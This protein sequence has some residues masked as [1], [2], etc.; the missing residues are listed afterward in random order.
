MRLVGGVALI[1]RVGK[2]Q[3]SPV[4]RFEI[5]RFRLID[6]TVT[7]NSELQRCQ[8]LSQKP[9]AAPADTTVCRNRCNLLVDL[10]AKTSD[11]INSRKKWCC[12]VAVRITSKLVLQ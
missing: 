1:T 5:R 2:M 10:P 8:L 3:S 6:E 11:N 4:K 7:R 12:V 9:H